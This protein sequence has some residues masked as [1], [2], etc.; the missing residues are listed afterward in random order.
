MKILVTG[1]NGYIGTILTDLLQKKG[2][3]V[4]GLDINYYKN[5]LL[6]PI[7]H[8]IE[9][10]T[11]DIR[12]VVNDDIKGFDAIIHLA[13]LSNDPLG[14]LDPYLTDDIN[15][16]GTM[17]I[18]K[19]AKKAGVKRFIYASSQSMYGI[20]NT[21]D[22][23][24][25]YKS[26]KI[27]I[28]SYAITKWK[29]ELELNKMNSNKFV[30]V[31]FRPSTVFGASPRLRCDV[32]FN[33]LVASAYT[34]G[35]V[36]IYSDGS[37]WRP[38]VHVRDVCKAFI[39]GLE[40][41]VRLVGGKAFNVGIAEGNFTVRQ[42]AKA[43]QAAVP[44][45][46]LIFLNEQTDPRSYRVSFCRILNELKD[47]YKPTWNLDNGG[48]ELVDYFKKVNFTENDFKGRKCIRLNQLKYLKET[49]KINHLLERIKD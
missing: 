24:D 13:A 21:I 3:S 43:A 9:H 46:D 33:N 15:F 8:E 42:L 48:K 25:E 10:I 27:P 29:A 16:N 38:V 34:T 40:A 5:C 47:Y 35:V 19:I 14:E 31:S 22:E 4:T 41:P 11:K 32:V 39:A 28:T 49:L 12:A 36:N 1:N 45:S 26:E 2:H 30:V 18:A 23:L 20:S 6:E 44:G 17:K 7:N 37:P